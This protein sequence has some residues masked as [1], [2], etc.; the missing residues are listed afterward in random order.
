MICNKCDGSGD[1]ILNM[2][3][4]WETCESCD[5]DGFL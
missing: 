5:G 1:I 4:D 3:G 2:E